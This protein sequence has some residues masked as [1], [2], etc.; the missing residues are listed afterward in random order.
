MKSFMMTCKEIVKTISSEQQL[1]WRKRIEIRFHL[2]ICHHCSKYA[3]QL[4]MVSK[5]L[6]KLFLA[7]EKQIKSEEVIHLEEKII[8]SLKK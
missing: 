3:Q 5:G 7:Q 2:L 1:N 4:E 8:N 6:K